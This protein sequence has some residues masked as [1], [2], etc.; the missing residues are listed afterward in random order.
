MN[1]GV[2]TSIN[3]LLDFVTDGVIFA[4]LDG[5]IT[6]VNIAC[7]QLLG[8]SRQQIIGTKIDET[9]L[10]QRDRSLVEIDK[11]P[12]QQVLKTGRLFNSD[13]ELGVKYEI[14][15]SDRS[16]F[17][18]QLHVFPFAHSEAENGIAVIIN[19][20]SSD[21][22]I[23]DA[24]SEFVALISH[25]LRTPV[26]II[27]W[28]VEK[29]MHQR[30]GSLNNRQLEYLK[31]VYR[32]NRRIIDLVQSVINVSRT[33]LRKLKHKHESVDI[34]PIVEKVIRD[35]EE[36]IEER[37]LEISTKLDR[38]TLRDSDAE[39]IQVV[40]RNVLSNA[41]HYTEEGGKVS[42]RLEPVKSGT[43]L[44]PDASVVAMA[45]GAI[46]TISDNGVGI[47]DEEKNR[48]FNKLHRGS[49]V[50]ALDVNGIGLGLYISE[51][52]MR[53]LGGHIWF[54]SELRNGTTF[55]LYFPETA[56]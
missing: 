46:L 10:L 21:E 25:Q 26:S 8:L 18:A 49:N 39:L 53:V 54:E 55:Y 22:R 42:L 3:V 15:R 29:L 52:F 35:S 56:K 34:K 20:K 40:C 50:L 31:E 5:E 23:E 45:D 9:I 12:F 48:I 44:D 13:Q 24:K 2:D 11:T 51:A 41:L 27:S 19:D 37:M 36:L 16:V 17:P 6:F 28:Y 32:S 4:R 1:A 14:A 7:L 43:T 33:D 38:I 47:P 30:K